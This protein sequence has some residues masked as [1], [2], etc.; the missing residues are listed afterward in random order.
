LGRTE[1]FAIVTFAYLV[2]SA[3]AFWV[4]GRSSGEHP[5]ATLFVADIGATLIIFGFSMRLDNGSVYDPYWSVVPPLIAL[6]W[7]AH[8]SAADGLR[9]LAVTVLVF[10]W[11]IRLTYNWA[12][13]WP[14]LHHED[15]RY[16]L[17]YA[18]SGMPKWAISLTGIHLFPTLQVFL[19]C[20]ALIPALARSEASF[21]ALDGIALL[22]TGGAILV[23][24]VAD[25]QLRAFA[26]TKQPG[27]IIETGL[28][29]Y[30]RH[31]N[32]VGE[33]GFWWGLFLFGVAADPSYW[34]TV[35]GPLAMT[36]MFHFASIPMLDQRSLE[37]RPGYAEHMQ[38]V[39]ALIPRIP[40]I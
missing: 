37:R 3:F 39:N 31:P 19:G 21:N 26:R 36:A 25:E 30:C 29:A 27:D 23:E 15:W 2:A 40:P 38:K 20:L 16:T 17:L 34:W 1:S 8:A 7:I 9:Q 12:R 6:F 14:G 35:I 32:Y 33:L 22:V 24:V 13:G 11:G 4:A 5:L 28:W 18:K 10:A